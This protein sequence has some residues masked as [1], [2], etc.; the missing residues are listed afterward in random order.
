MIRSGRQDLIAKL[1]GF[2]FEDI[3]NMDELALFFRL[4]PGQTLATAAAKGTKQCK[5]RLTVA[6][7][8][9][10]TGTVKAKPFVIGK[11]KRPRSFR[12]F[13]PTEFV[14]YASNRKAW[15]T[16]IEFKLT[17]LNSTSRISNLNFK[18]L[19]RQNS[20]AHVQV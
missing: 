2:E 1:S 3:F 15:M 11:S 6:L 4:Q 12:R 10:A 14:D 18:S 19:R 7:C 9:N 8:C 20:V 17:S 16:S 5:D 13:D